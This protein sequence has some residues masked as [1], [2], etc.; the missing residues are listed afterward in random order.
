[1][2]LHITVRPQRK[3]DRIEMKGNDWQVSIRAK[4]KDNEANEY[5]V[6]YLSDVL[7]LP[8]SAILIKRGHR[9][10]TKQ[11]EI[12]ASEESILEKLNSISHK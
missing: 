3:F 12:L 8:I 6:R 10:K 9:S 5:L 7:K 11:V 1:M 4:P 2:I